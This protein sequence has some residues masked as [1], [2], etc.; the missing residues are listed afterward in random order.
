MHWTVMAR[1]LLPAGMLLALIAAATVPAAAQQRRFPTP[2]EAVAKLVEALGAGDVDTMVSLFGEEHRDE[3]LG[4]DLVAARAEWRQA[5]AWAKEGVALR[6]ARDAHLIIVI[7]RRAWPAPIPL[8][9]DNGG[10]RFDTEAGIE[11]MINRRIGRNELAAI[12]FARA[13]VKAQNEYASVDRRGDGVIEYAQILASTPGKRDGLF[14]PANAGEP[15]SPL[16]PFAGTIGEYLAGREADAPYRGYFYRVL[17]RQGANAPGGAYDYV[18]NGRMVAGYALLA[19]PAEYGASG[20]MT[21]LVNRNGVL[22]Q[23][24]LG[25]GTTEIARAVDAYDPDATWQPVTD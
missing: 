12:E 17:K 25:A 2:E 24:D 16:G 4:R 21:F 8:I 9:N 22:L 6:P 7:G 5:H 3:I 18:I 20:V 14:W 1:G 10:W 19:H 23:K 11:E 13:F 15:V